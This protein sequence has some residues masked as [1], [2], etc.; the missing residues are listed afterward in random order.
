MK[1]SIGAAPRAFG[2]SLLLMT[3]SCVAASA[4]QN[5]QGT[6]ELGDSNPFLE[7]SVEDGK[8]D[9]G[10]L[11]LSGREIEVTLEADI[12]IKYG[13]PPLPAPLDLAQYAVTYLRERKAFYLQI[14][15]ED[16]QAPN[17]VQWK[18]D[19]EWITAAQAKKLSST[20]L[21]HFRIP[22]MNAVLLN[23]EANK[24]SVGQVI[25]ARVPTA[26]YDV[27]KSA[28]K[29]CADENSHISLSQSVYWYLWNPDR[30]GCKLATQDMT[31]TVTKVTSGNTPS[32]PEYNQLWSDNQLTV[33]VQYGKLE[34]G[35]VQS[36]PNWRNADQF[37]KWL[38]DAGFREQPKQAMGRRFSK[39]TAAGRTET[40]DVYYPDL[41]EDVTDYAHKANWQKEVSEHEV[42]IYLGH[43]VL[44]TGSAYDDVKY[45]SFYQILYIGGCLGYEY[46]V[47]PVLQ[48]KGDWGKVDIVSSITENLYSE[49][50]PGTAAFLAKLFKGFETSGKMSWQQIMSGINSRLGH[51]HFGVSGARDNRFRP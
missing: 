12:T 23:S 48:G 30:S 43:S 36:D 45:P 1:P 18:V 29:T 10:Y 47:N 37:C 28:G 7:E 33:S 6:D 34:D 49:N 3:A 13:V 41:F 27:M 9:T 4:D 32:Y 40:V 15:A 38:A 2:L 25:K 39:T 51:A 16:D 5:P 21:T 14:L 46:Y 31:L 19:G 22:G 26:L 35:D 44:G 8:A 42:V 17:R 50:N 24:V 20:K 11:N